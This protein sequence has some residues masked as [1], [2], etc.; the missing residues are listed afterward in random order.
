MIFQDPM[1]SLNPVLTIGD[2]I[3]EA[4]QAHNPRD[5]RRRRPEARRA[6]ARGRRRAVRRASVRP[7]PARVLGR[8]AQRAMIAMAIANDPAVLI[9]DEPTTALDVTIQAQIVEVMRAAQQETHA[10][11]ILITHDL[12]LIAELADRVVVMYAGRVV[13]LGDVYTIFNSPAPPVHGRAH[14]QPRARGHGPGVARPIPASRRASSTAA[15]VRLPPALR[16]SPRGGALPHRGARAAELRRGRRHL[17][18]CH[19]AEELAA[20]HVTAAPRR[21]SRHHEPGGGGDRATAGGTRGARGR[22]PRVEGLVKHFPIKSGIFKRTVGQVQ[23]VDGV[24]LSVARAR[25]SASSASRAAASRRSDARSSS[26]SSRPPGRSSSRARTSRA[27][28]GA[29]C[30]RSGATSRSSSRIPYASLN[31]RMTVREIVGEPLRIH[32]LYRRR[33]EGGA[34]SRSSCARSA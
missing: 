18:A 29:R 23:A 30:G 32:G 4:I 13:E 3:A 12:G 10:A 25:R 6:P 27:S 15:R 31:P 11:I 26:C 19:F 24:D 21:W 14:E 28:S 1:T 8:H 9:A 2:Q 16:V 20:Q 22:D 7:V 17:S 33:G 34:A 5:E